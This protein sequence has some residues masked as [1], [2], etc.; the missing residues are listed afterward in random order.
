MSGS[1]IWFDDT[2]EHFWRVP[3]G[4]EMPPGNLSIRNL[5][6]DSRSVE[7]GSLDAWAI[8]AEETRRAVLDELRAAA[9]HTAG[10]LGVTAQGW[11]TQ[12]LSALPEEV[13]WDELER[14]LGPMDTW[15][16]TSQ[17]TVKTGRE[18]VQRT[19]RQARDTL[20]RAGRV[21]SSTVRSARTVGKVV[22]DNPELAETATR[23]AETLA[24]RGRKDPDKS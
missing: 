4:E 3:D 18:S 22:L 17:E 7:A 1:T 8:P 6:G 20:R 12:A 15:V 5:S 13:S 11:W 21:A 9:R 19:A 2:R 14:R 16:A 24:G 23:W 10:A